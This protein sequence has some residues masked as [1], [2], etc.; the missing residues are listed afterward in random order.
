MNENKKELSKNEILAIIQ[1]IVNNSLAEAEI[2]YF[3][4]AVYNNGMAFN[5]TVI[6]M[7]KNQLS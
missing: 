7:K 1:D 5:E 2:A 4:S 3:I 6:S